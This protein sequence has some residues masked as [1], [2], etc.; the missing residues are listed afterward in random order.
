MCTDK[1]QNSMD[2]ITKVSSGI[3]DA[4]YNREE[5]DDENA[6]EAIR[7]IFTDNAENIWF[8]DDLWNPCRRFFL[9]AVVSRDYY[10]ISDYVPGHVLLLGLCGYMYRFSA[11][12]LANVPKVEAFLLIAKGFEKFHRRF[13]DDAFLDCNYTANLQVDLEFHAVGLNELGREC[14]M[15]E[16]ARQM[17]DKETGYLF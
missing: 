17:Q 4:L 5:Y 9:E 13:N 15:Y 16:M 11:I 12:I 7:A 14:V 2:I 3:A 10:R 8:E 1:E 6:L